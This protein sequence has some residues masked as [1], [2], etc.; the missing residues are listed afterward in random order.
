MV[1][2]WMKRDRPDLWER[3]E[4]AKQRIAPNNPHISFYKRLRRV[5]T[6]RFGL[7][8][9]PSLPNYLKARYRYPEGTNL[10]A[11]YSV[12]ARRG[13]R[14]TERLRKENGTYVDNR[15]I[16]LRNSSSPMSLAY[17]KSR[18]IS[19]EEAQ[20]TI[21]QYASKG[22]HAALKRQQK[23]KCE[24]FVQD[25][26]RELGEPFASPFRFEAFSFDFVVPA[27]Q[28]VIE[29]NGTYWHCDPRFFKA[30]DR[31]KFPG[32]TIAAQVV[33]DKD[34]DKRQRLESCGYR[35]LYVWEHDIIHEP[36]IVKERIKHAVGRD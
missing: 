21:K 36:E 3:L 19:D 17:Y 18:G 4:L 6:D 14:E 35:V 31:V 24:R 2:D 33:W 29:V 15:P 12:A 32:K 13:A 7:L 27:N 11:M 20:L 22:A 8:R 26:L 9:T 1:I 5:L 10:V 30:I 34:T 28:L 16:E 25:V 23:N